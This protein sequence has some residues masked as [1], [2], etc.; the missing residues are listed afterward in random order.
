MAEQKSMFVLDFE[1]RRSDILDWASTKTAST[2]TVHALEDTFG[3]APTHIQADSIVATPET[4]GMCHAINEQRQTN[5]LAPLEIIEVMHLKGIEGGIISSSAIR[6]GGMDS[7]GHPWMKKSLR[8][9]TLKMA[10]ALDSE[11]KTPMGTLFAGPE[12]DPEVA[13]TAA[14]DGMPPHV[15][16]LIAVGDVTTKTLL[17][18]G[19]TPDLALIDGMTKRSKLEPEHLVNPEAFEHRLE[20]NNPAG[21]L[22][23]SLCSALQTALRTEAPLL[24]EV[25]GEEDLAPLVIHCFAPLGTVVLYGQPRTGVVMQITTLAVKERC[26]NLINLFEVIE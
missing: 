18:M 1:Q 6:N 17:E 10:P 12:D 8:E 23:P 22:T 7:E 19:I 2:I 26:R 16:L 15:N 13:M 4:I 3:P 11:L 20:A 14:L 25:D 24:L 9:S 5:G 21:L